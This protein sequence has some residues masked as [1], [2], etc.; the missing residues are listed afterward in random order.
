[1]TP[2]G[3]AVAAGPCL[4]LDIGA[5][6]VAAGLVD[7]DG[8]LLARGQLSIAGG[9]DLLDRVV[10]LVTEVRGDV[11]TVLLGV[12]CAGPM[13]ERGEYVSPLNIPA[14]RDFALRERL[15]E[16]LGVEVHVDGDARALALAEGRFGAARGQT[17]YLSIVVSSGVGGGV[18][19]DGRLVDGD[20]G[21]AGHV[22]HLTVVPD[23]RECACGSRG[24]LEAEAS[25]LAILAMT[26]RP[27][28]EADA[29]TRTR[30]ARLVGRAVG[31]LAAVLDV[32]R[33]YVGGSV[34]LGYG[35]GFFESANAAAREVARLSYVEDL[36]IEPTS[37]GP[38]G[39]LLG[40][41]LVAWR[42][43]S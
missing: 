9:S 10:Q 29:A 23:G 7:P 28:E 17:A 12:A 26:G 19:L 27:P 38:D 35:R 5:T 16:R 1:M 39:G 4:T 8:V 18:V 30:V 43:A 37:L 24:C 6:K 15:A 36:R 32:S 40:A 25:G 41:A 14:W 33:C 31:T 13:R 3:P 2:G 21:N 22:G 11:A 34:A 20:S 42:G